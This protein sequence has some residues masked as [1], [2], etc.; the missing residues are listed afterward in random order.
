[1]AG[2][3]GGRRTGKGRVSWFDSIYIYGGGRSNLEFAWI[4]LFDDGS[5]VVVDALEEFCGELC[6]VRFV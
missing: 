2:V 3:D 4:F 1:M 6:I 5:D